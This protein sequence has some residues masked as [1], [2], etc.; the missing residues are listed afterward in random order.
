MIIL[1]NI[2][3][4]IYRSLFEENDDDN[5]KRF[6]CITQYPSAIRIIN[7]IINILHFSLPFIINF[8]SALII[9]IMSTRQ[10][11]AIKKKQKYQQILNEQIQQHKNLLI[12]PCVL[13][14]LGIPRLIISFTKG[15]MKSSS[16]SWLF[17]MAYFISLIP[18]LLTFILFVLPSS[19]YKQAFRQVI[20]RYRNMIKL[21][22]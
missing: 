15:C 22:S 11:A 19:T 4:P 18:P 5:K 8:I 21:D 9:I 12:G 7:L 13:I 14:I 3:D 1:T 2:H 17:L 16:D 10:Q 20:S 6:W